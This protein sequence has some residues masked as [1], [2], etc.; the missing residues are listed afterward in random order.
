[1][2]AAFTYTAD[3]REEFEA[4]TARLLRRRFIG[5]VLA[6]LGLFLFA[7]YFLAMVR[8]AIAVFGPVGQ[9]PM[10]EQ[11]RRVVRDSFDSPGGL[12]ALAVLTL[13]ESVICL[14]CIRSIR[15]RRVGPAELVKLSQWVF[16]C[17][18]A[19]AIAA[20]VAI[21]SVGFPWW[22][23]IMHV[24]ATVLLPWTPRQAIRPIL[25]LLAINGATIAFFGGG[26][27]WVRFVKVAFTVFAGVPGTLTAMFRHS[28][29]TERFKLRF[30]Q[31]RY[32]QMRRELTDARRIHESLFPRPHLKGPVK[33]D[34][35][36]EPMRQIGG[37][38]LYARY[39][40]TPSGLPSLSALI[41]DVTGHG[42]AAALTVNRLY[43][44]VERLFAENPDA[45]PGEVLRALN[46]YVHLTLAGHSVYATA[47]CLRVDAEAG[48][49]EYASGGHPPAFIRAVDGTIEQLAATS[50]VL[51]ASL[52]PHFD[53]APEVRR[54]GPGDTLIAYTDGAIE[55]RNE[56]GRMLGI[57][58]LQRVL[59]AGGS[60]DGSWAAAI[61]AAVDAHRLGP[62]EDD[63]LVVEIRRALTLETDS[64]ITTGPKTRTGTAVGM[65]A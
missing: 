14:G 48:T 15:A 6:N 9:A 18:G 38:Y 54:F 52:P 58:G 63:T 31:S 59:A 33:F 29:R 60:A 42:I 32:G 61:V 56:M 44:E 51:G 27:L 8:L 43:G 35:R 57:S 12:L 53:P 22:I 19:I 50:F 4:E 24:V 23:A 2:T 30:L 11:L 25:L 26:A 37:D 65:K 49:I 39:L 13:T 1:M 41:I 64:A 7:Y 3:Y 36:Y 17:T 45:S 28:R 62:P 21:R 46:R 55:A 10:G 40:P 20:D 16:V 47:L 5:F 34:Y